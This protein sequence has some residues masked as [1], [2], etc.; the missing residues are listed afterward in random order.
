MSSKE[1]IL[2][3]DLVYAISTGSAIN[4]KYIAEKIGHLRPEG[5]S[6]E[7]HISELRKL[8]LSFLD[9][10]CAEESDHH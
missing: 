2:L 3:E 9:S 6:K 7:I 4:G 10:L 1:K 8:A 5:A